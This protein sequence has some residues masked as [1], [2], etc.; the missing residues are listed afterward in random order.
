M[1]DDSI[2]TDPLKVHKKHNINMENKI[3]HT[4]NDVRKQMM[5]NDE[6]ETVR[7]NDRHSKDE[8]PKL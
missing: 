3:Q 4:N 8:A 1:Q 2:S 7:E 6:S 5:A